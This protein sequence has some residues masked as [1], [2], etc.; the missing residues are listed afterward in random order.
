MRAFAVVNDA[1]SCGAS[2]AMVAA[3]FT[4]SSPASLSGMFL[5]PG[6]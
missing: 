2:V 6:T 1:G 3:A 4:C 5:R